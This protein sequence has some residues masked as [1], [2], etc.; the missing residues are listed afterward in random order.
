MGFAIVGRIL[1]VKFGRVLRRAGNITVHIH[2]DISIYSLPCNAHT[3]KKT[4][5]F[6][7]STC[8]NAF[9]NP[10]LRIRFNSPAAKCTQCKHPIPALQ[11]PSLENATRAVYYIVPVSLA[12]HLPL[13]SISGHPVPARDTRTDLAR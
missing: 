6:H 4:D 5:N 13:Q 2:S 7:R 12:Q 1:M 9:Q 8:K 3:S 10:K 11:S